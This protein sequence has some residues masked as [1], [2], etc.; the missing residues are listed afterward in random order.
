M[1][2]GI[3]TFFNYNNYGASLQCYGLYKILKKM[4]HDVEYLDYTCPYI[5][6][7]FK[8]DHL[9]KKGLFGYIYSTVGYI[10]Y[11][12][13]RKKFQKFRELI[14]HTKPLNIHN[15]AEMGSDY[16][17]YITGSDQVWSVKLTDFDTTYF[18]D[19]VKDDSRKYSYAASFGENAVKEANRSRY[20]ELLEKFQKISVRE[21][22]GQKLTQEIA[23]QNSEIT[24]DP[25][26]LL[27]AEEWQKVCS[28][29]RVKGKYLLVYQLGFSKQLIHAV[30]SVAKQTGLQVIYIPFPLGGVVKSKF[31]I[32]IGPAEWLSLFKNAEYIITD[33][34]HGVIFSIIFRKL[35]LAVVDGQH[36]N[37]RAISLLQKLHLEERI[38]QDDNFGDIVKKIDYEKVE[39]ILNVDI[40]ASKTWLRENI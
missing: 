31:S 40:E 18:L 1:K 27:N 29:K 9:K 5:G 4:G 33:S 26:L 19:F 25:T 36:K 20:K 39:S 11:L 12:P 15:I 16:D 14:P 24:V 7:P 6:N 23:G 2:I 8:L 32:S 38:A 17:K 10:C 13:R 34:Y 35:F 30:K 22:Y 37:Q 21:D 3:L 28:K